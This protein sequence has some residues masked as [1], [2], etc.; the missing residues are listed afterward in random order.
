MGRGRGG[1]CALTRSPAELL[2]RGPRQ[3]SGRRGSRP[4]SAFSVSHFRPLSARAAAGR[5]ACGGPL[6][7]LH[8]PPV[9][10]PAGLLT[11]CLADP[12]ARR[13]PVVPCPCSWSRRP[14]A[15]LPLDRRLIPPLR[16]SSDGR[17][18]IGFR[19]FSAIGASRWRRSEGRRSRK[20]DSARRPA[21]AQCS[22]SQS[23][24]TTWTP[25]DWRGWRRCPGG[26]RRSAPK[27]GRARQ[28]R[29]RTPSQGKPRRP[30]RPWAG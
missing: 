2:E 20:A 7:Q 6:A 13:P 24:R 3:G 30:S 23:S 4:S 11:R 12:L 10:S 25:S 21:F 1:D 22:G 9:T 15:H 17:P 26:G 16:F 8:R 19:G 29:A 18:F 27:P 5:G 14:A 28:E